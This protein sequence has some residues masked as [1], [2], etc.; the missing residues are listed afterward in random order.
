LDA[1]FAVNDPSALG[2]VEA[3]EAA[4]RSGRVTVVT[5][6]GSPEGV[7]AIQAGRLHSSS[8]Q[9]PREIGRI[10]AEKAYDHLAG[11]PVGKDVKLPVR[12]LTKDIAGEA[13]EPGGHP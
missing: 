8:A 3:I 12:L 13:P 4:G 7:A 9:T 6:D 2:A 11:K 5:V 10:A 1:A